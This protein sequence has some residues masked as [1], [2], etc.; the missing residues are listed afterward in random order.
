MQDWV[1]VTLIMLAIVGAGGF[2]GWVFVTI[3]DTSIAVWDL[4]KKLKLFRTDFEDSVNH[5]QPT[6]GEMKEI[7]SL[8]GLKESQ[9]QRTLKEYVREIRAG[10]TP[11]L[12]K[13]LTLIKSYLDSYKNDEPFENL[14]SDLRI[15]LERLRENLN[16]QLLLEPLTVHIKELVSINSKENRKLK[17]YTVGSFFIGLLGI[18]LALYFYVSPITAT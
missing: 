10:R 17:F 18:A 14:P 2:F 13:H 5:S 6:W 4:N 16:D 9:I 1:Y 7:A 3:I 15:H 8:R 12:E 11:D